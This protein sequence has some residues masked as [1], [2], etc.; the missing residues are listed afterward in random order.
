[1]GC[2]AYPAREAGLALRLLRDEPGIDLVVIDHRSLDLESLLAELRKIR[3]DVE[4]V[5]VSDS[6]VEAAR[7]ANA[8]ILKQL[9]RPWRVGDLVQL[10]AE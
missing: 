1:M 8:G 4:V 9:H 7:F 3:P 6:P 5:G 2:I 10:L